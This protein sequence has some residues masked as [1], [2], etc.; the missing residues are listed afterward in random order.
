A[1]LTGYIAREARRMAAAF[2]HDRLD[3][4]FTMA[5]D[6]AVRICHVPL[7]DWTGDSGGSGIHLIIVCQSRADLV[8]RWGKNGAATIINNAGT[9]I[10]YGGSKDAEDLA[11]WLQLIGDRAEI[12]LSVNCDGMDTSQSPRNS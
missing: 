4:P 11:A 5:L 8:K 7:D 6:E 12:V 2:T 9:F 1:A 3:P 10:L